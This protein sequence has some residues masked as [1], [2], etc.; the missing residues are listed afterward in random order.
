MVGL[1]RRGTSPRRAT[2]ES[3]L[4]DE[5]DAVQGQPL[6]SGPASRW[7]NWRRAVDGPLGA[8][9]QIARDVERRRWQG[10]RRLRGRGTLDRKKR[11]LRLSA[12]RVAEGVAEIARQVARG[13]AGLCGR[14]RVARRAATAVATMAAAWGLIVGAGRL[15]RDA[16]PAGR[17]GAAGSARPESQ[18]RLER[19][20]E[21]EE[22]A[23]E[24][25]VPDSSMRSPGLLGGKRVFVDRSESG[26]GKRPARYG[27]A[28]LRPEAA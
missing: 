21:D 22:E 9:P 19:E 7:V 4:L 12:Q 11:R 15:G 25:P 26:S 8:G 28:A 20:R 27:H 16:A 2:M 10:L 13:V 3:P 24:H 17:A 18:R 5:P 6:R 1:R 23:E 14:I